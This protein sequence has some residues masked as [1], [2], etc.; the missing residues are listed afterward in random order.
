[1]DLFGNTPLEYALKSKDL[2]AVNAV[3]EGLNSLSDNERNSVLQ[4]I[5]INSLVREITPDLDKV[6]SDGGTSIPLTQSFSYVVEI[7]KNYPLKKGDV[8]FAV[9]SC[10]IYGHPIKN[11]L[12]PEADHAYGEDEDLALVDTRIINTPIPRDFSEDSISLLDTIQNLES[13]EILKSKVITK[14][15]DR[16]WALYGKK[17]YLVQLVLYIC[18]M[19]SLILIFTFGFEDQF[20]VPALILTGLFLLYE[21]LQL[22]VQ[23]L[24]YFKDIINWIDMIRFGLIIYCIV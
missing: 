20:T 15:L 9:S 12:H 17:F 22:C 16:K 4:K 3:Y 2:A 19:L 24:D 10:P 1:V 18:L 5:S 23:K 6:I 11:A 13:D 21:F 14:I 8:K 7:P